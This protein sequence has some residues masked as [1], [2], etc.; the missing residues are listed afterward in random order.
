MSGE[1]RQQY[2]RDCHQRMLS[3]LDEADW[4]TRRGHHEDARRFKT[5]AELEHRKRDRYD[6]AG[7]FKEVVPR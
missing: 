6:D 4:Y 1:D 2:A 5:L 3:L 7:E